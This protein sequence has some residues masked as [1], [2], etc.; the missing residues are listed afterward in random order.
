VEFIEEDTEQLRWV[1]AAAGA[2]YYGGYGYYNNGRYQDAYGI[3]VCP[4]Q[5]PY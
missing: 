2:A 5:D 3:T 4:Q 1:A